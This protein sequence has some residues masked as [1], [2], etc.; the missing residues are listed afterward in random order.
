MH[1]IGNAREPHLTH[2][3]AIREQGDV[4]LRWD[5]RNAPALRWR[6]LRS[7]RGFSESAD[8]P[9]GSDQTVVSESADC[10]VRDDQ[11][12]GDD[13]YYYTVFVQDELGAW[14]CQMKVE[15]GEGQR[16]H[17]HRPSLDRASSLPPG[18]LDH[19]FLIQPR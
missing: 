5:L 16:L 9:V 14:H 4:I 3:E 11:A 19:F 13:A 17:W 18:P 10:G 15:I 6:V 8:A 2:F 12:S 1:L 7:E